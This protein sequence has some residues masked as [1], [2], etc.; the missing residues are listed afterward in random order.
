MQKYRRRGCV[1]AVRLDLDTEGFT[2][3]K[4]GGVQFCKKGD[5]IVNYK[6]DA[7]TVDAE[8]FERTYRMLSPGV[9]EKTVSVWAERANEAGVIQ[10]KEGSTAYVQGDYLVFNEPGRKDGYAMSADRFHELYEA[11]R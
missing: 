6:S 1:T 4:W 2:Y 10:T 3:Q 11:E 8:S 9:Y 7:Y 5:W